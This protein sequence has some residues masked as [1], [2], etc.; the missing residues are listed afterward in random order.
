[1]DQWLSQKQMVTH[2]GT[3]KWGHKGKGDSSQLAGERGIWLPPDLVANLTQLV[4]LWQ[5]GQWILTQSWSEYSLDLW[6]SARDDTL[7]LQ[8]LLDPKTIWSLRWRSEHNSFSLAFI[9]LPSYLWSF[10][11]SSS[12][13]WQYY[14]ALGRGP[15]EP[16]LSIV[17]FGHWSTTFSWLNLH[18]LLC[19]VLYIRFK[20]ARELQCEIPGNFSYNLEGHWGFGW[21][22]GN[23]HLQWV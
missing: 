7:S 12:L 14:V 2:R 16:Y 9:F 22:L 4:F 21:Q 8:Q 15:G 5:P 3:W 13:G 23:K 6:G 10:K 18:P 19:S 17:L 1:M 11:A 20:I